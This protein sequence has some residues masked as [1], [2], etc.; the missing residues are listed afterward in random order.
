MLKKITFRKFSIT[1]LLLLVALIL[2]NYPEEINQE[3]N[4]DSK[5][6]IN[7]YLIDKNN[8]VALTK[9]DS[10]AGKINEKIEFIIDGLTIGSES[11]IPDGF[12]KI[13][14]ANTKLLDY[15]I[16]N[17]LLKINFSKEFLTISSDDE[18]KLIESLVFSLTAIN[19]IEK[20][21][22]FVE[23]NKLDELPNSHKKLDLY[24]DRNYG[25]NK[26]IDITTFSGTKMVTV[27]YL[28]KDVNYYYIPISY[29][30]SD[31]EDKIEIIVNSLKSNRL[32]SSNLSSHLDYQVELMN[33]EATE[34]SF[35]LD[36][37][38]FLLSS[39]HDGKLKEELKYAISYSIYDTFG[40]E[41]VVFLVNSQKIDEFI[42]EK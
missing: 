9:I 25:I 38:E 34:E 32:N 42:L 40:V 7:I 37:N 11:S 5:Q 12:R 18:N 17:N 28:N 4:N 10:N 8:L 6:Q 20:V 29:I 31:E 23:G 16:T 22:I 36:F 2:Y 39:A 26:V 35:L 19:P 27:Y 24:L 15:T 21:M 33:Y 30:V 14:P 1:T 3:Y 41:N 13:I